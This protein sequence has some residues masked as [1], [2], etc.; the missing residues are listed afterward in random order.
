MGVARLSAKVVTLSE[1]QNIKDQEEFQFVAT[2]GG[3]DPLHVGHLR[4]IKHSSDIA[5]D[6]GFKL[7]VIVNG[8]GFLIRKKGKPFMSH[9]E[10]ME[11][12][13]G[14]DGVD[15]VVGW[16]DGSQTVTE[17]LRIIRPAIFTK[18]GD[19]SS[20][21]TIPE[22]AVCAAIGCQVLWGIGGTDKVQSSS[23]LIAQSS[24]PSK[25]FSANRPHVDRI[26]KPW[27][28]EEIFV[29]TD[30]YVGKLIHVD[31]QQR[32]SRQYHVVKDETIYVKSGEMVL[33]INS[34]SDP[35]Y[36]Q[37]VLREGESFRIAPGLVHRF[38]ALVGPVDIIEVSTPELD[39]VVRLSDDY[40]RVQ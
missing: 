19:R 3:F 11:I 8:D 28:F 15:F 38:C 33:E 1:L 25:N 26:S 35:L 7:V 24:G 9:Q 14:L 22:M 6:R 32:L 13:A 16:D 18:G 34:P 12:I 23:N 21:E 40:G 29:H 31:D 27:G 36:R 20:P 17:C 37:V 5:L 2:S 10:R 4:C 39:D 30:R